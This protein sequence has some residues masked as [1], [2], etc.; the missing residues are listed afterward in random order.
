MPLVLGPGA[1]ILLLIGVRH[2]AF[3]VLEAA[4]ELT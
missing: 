4:Q 2:G 1:S 3:A